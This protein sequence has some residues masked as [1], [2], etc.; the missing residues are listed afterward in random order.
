MKYSKKALPLIIDYLEIAS[1]DSQH[2]A[3]RR[4]KLSKSMGISSTGSG[5]L[6]ERIV[7]IYYDTIG[8]SYKSK[9]GR[10]YCE[11][12]DGSEIYY[13]PDGMTCDDDSPSRYIEVKLRRYRS[14][15]T[16]HE[17]IP[18]IISK[19]DKILTSTGCKSILFLLCDDEHKYN[20]GW[21]SIVKL[22]AD[23]KKLSQYEKHTQ[24]DHSRVFEKI[25]LG[26]EIAEELKNYV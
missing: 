17:K 18:A 22:Q 8:V 19:Y 1:R 12:V 2:D 5:P 23:R 16:A 3:S 7:K 9:P 13:L 6:G 26:T 15:G 4:K 24:D 20:R 11:D 21:Q 14:S 25:V 10:V